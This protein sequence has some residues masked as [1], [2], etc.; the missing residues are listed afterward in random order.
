MNLVR[1]LVESHGE[2][3]EW[4]RHLHQHPETAFE[5]Y[6]TA[7]FVSGRLSEF[8]IE[9]RSGFAGTGVLG[10]L[11]RGSS[12]RIIALRAELDA[13]NLEEANGFEHRSRRPGKM[14]GCGHDGHMAML[15][16]AAKYLASN[17]NFD[18]TVHF[19][20]QPGEEAGNGALKMMDDGLFDAIEP[21]ALYGM[22]NFPGLG[23]GCFASRV[24]Q[25]MASMDAFRIRIHGVGGHG[26]YPSRA[27]TPILPAC[28][29][30][31]ALNE[32]VA[33]QIPSEQVLAMSVAEII[34]GSAINVIPQK[35]HIA[36]TV[37]SLSAVTQSM[38]EVAIPRICKGI[39]AAYGVDCDV[40]YERIYPCL[41]NSA[42]ETDQALAVAEMIVGVECVSADYAPLMASEDFAWML[43]RKPGNYIVIGNGKSGERGSTNVHHPNYDFNDEILPFGASYWVRLT[44]TLLGMST[45]RHSR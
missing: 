19:I 35:A 4:R 26:A 28:A 43:R 23:V 32:H 36:G 3:I 7:E 9:T 24:G 30:V 34:A 18:G 41:E 16:G 1:E 39:C 14:H 13:L 33:A 25:F 42:R 5:E 2:M 22:H 44:E 17:G 10:T 27:V 11:S 8:G 40:D 29:I 12:D 15:L 21:E 20:F 31:S 38:M 37:R 6:D 45:E